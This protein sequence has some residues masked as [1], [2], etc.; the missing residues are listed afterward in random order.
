MPPARNPPSPSPIGGRIAVSLAACV[1]AIGAWL[2][3]S[4][5]SEVAA[6]STARVRMAPGETA[7]RSLRRAGVSARDAGEAGALIGPV[8]G[9]GVILEVALARPR[10]R[11]GQGRL[12]GVSVPV[13]GSMPIWF[14][15]TYDGAL[16]IASRGPV[17][18]PVVTVAEGTLRGSLY[19]SAERAGANPALIEQVSAL[20]ARRLDFARDLAPG[21]RFRLVFRRTRTA[22]GET[23]DT[24][25]LLYAEIGGRNGVSRFYAFDDH[26]RAEFLNSSGAATANSLLRTPVE[27]ARIS[28]IF[29][30]RLHPILGY[31]RMHQGIDFAAPIGTPVLAAGDGVVVEARVW[32]GYGA[33]LR[34]RHAGGLETGYAH[35]SAYADGVRPGLT[36]RQGQ[37]I[38]FVGQTGEA[39]GP[40][41]HY[42]VW[43][44]GVRIDPASLA[45]IGAAALRGD[46]LVSFEAQKA[47]I[48][49]LLALAPPRTPGP[50]IP[51]GLKPALSDLEPAVASPIRLA[52]E[53]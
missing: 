48:D 49:A 27:G 24:G 53:A 33:W 13:D 25:A 18:T 17:D 4:G 28:S 5:P 8:V 47:R 46:R 7:E 3:T 19:D 31:S 9:P 1:I 52:P 12:A 21:D 38:G 37:V 6:A 15:R 20:F 22:A 11:E 40:H 29:G 2:G 42:E 39:T 23:V 51:S 41:L 26:G 45:S 10:S 44:S 35:L 14:S 50:G 30:M 43:R 16:R 36:V 32:G 34:V